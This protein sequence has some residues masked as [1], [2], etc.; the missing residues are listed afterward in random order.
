MNAKQNL[1]NALLVP[2]LKLI[3][4]QFAKSEAM[5]V[6]FFAK[7]Y[8]AS[9]YKAEIS[10]QTDKQMLEALVQAW[11]FVQDRKSSAPK[12]QFS[13]ITA[14]LEGAKP[15]GGRIY[16]LVNDM[17][18]LVDSIRQAVNRGGVSIRSV[19]NAVLQ[20][21]RETKSNGSAGRLKF[22][23]TDNT[24]SQ[25]G[26]AICCINCGVI[27]VSQMALLERELK[28]TLKHVSVAVRDYLPICQ[29][30][31]N[32][33]SAL[34][35]NTDTVPVSEKELNESVKFIGWL[36]SNHFSF[37]GYEQYKIKYLKSG[38]MVELQTDSTLGISKFKSGLKERVELSSL[39]KGT[40]EH[41]LKKQICSFA[42][43]SNR[44]KV[45]RSVHLDYVL[46]KE[47][48]SK[49]RVVT[50]HRFVG[51][52]TSSV[53]YQTALEIPLIRDKVNQVLDESGF[54]PNGHSIKDLLQVINV[55]PRDELFQISK[56][57][58]YSTALEITQIQETRISKLFVR[59]DSYGKFFSCLVYMPRDIYNTKVRQQVQN[60]LKNELQ[61]AEVEFS[62]YLSE[63]ML[64]RIHFI[65]RTPEIQ[66]VKYNRVKLE[67]QMVRLVKPWDDYFLE[68][69]QE[70]YPDAEAENLFSV[71]SSCYS[72]SYKETYSAG[73][74]VIDI[75]RLARVVESK[76]LALDLE[77]CDP[78]SFAELSFKIFSFK[79]Q[80]ILSDV[81]PVLENFGLS[82]IGE[83]AFKLQP[84]CEEV[85]WMHD[86][87]LSRKNVSAKLP[88]DLEEKFEDAFA[89]VW[90]KKTEDDSF[91]QLVIA[92][93][94]HWR[95][96]ALLRAY[97]AYLKQIQFGYSAQYIADTLAQ[98]KDI[99]NQLVGYFYAQFDP[100]IKSSKRPAA[101]KLRKKIL[102]AIDKVSNLAEDS[103]LRSILELVD[104]TLRTNYF[105]VDQEG[106]NKDYFS[107]KFESAS[108]KNMPLPKPM[109]EIFVFS[110]NVEGVH[111]RGGKVARGGLRWSDRCEDYRTEVLGLVKAQQV[112]NSIIVPVGAKG[113]FVVKQSSTPGDR[114]ELMR[115]GISCYR[116]FIRG[117]LDITDN[118]VADKVKPPVQVVRKDK[119]DPYLVVAADKGTA[120]FSDIANG[121]AEDYKF[122]LGDG[123]ASGGSN[124]YDHKQMGITAKGAWVSVQRHFREQGVNIQKQDFSVVGIGDMSG[125]VFGN[126][127]LLSKHICL[128]AAFNHLHIFIDP[129]PD[130]LVSFKE[131]QRLFKL[132]RSGWGD[133]DEKLISKGG[134][135]FQRSAKS[136]VISSE[137][138]EKFGI[139]QTSATPNELISMLLK[140]PVD[141]LWNGGI[142]TYA[143]A[144]SESH[145]E[146][147]D[148][149]NDGLRVDANELRCK[150]IGEGGNLGFTQ[151]SRIEFGLNGGISLTD[152]IDNS[153]GVDCSDH[154]VNIKILLNKQMA[155]KNLNLLE[156]NK[157]LK[158]MTAQVSSLVLD[159][160]YSQVQAIGVAQAQM[161]ARGKEHI[162]LISWLEKHADL[163]RKLEYLPT[164]DELEE[165]IV[166]NKFLTRPE[167]SIVTSYMK[168]F[169]KKELV[170]VGYIDND[171]L[172]PYLYSAFPEK[173]RE[174]HQ[175]AIEAH[176][177]RREIISTQLANSIVNL[178]GPSFVYRLVDATGTLPCE[179]VKAAVIVLHIYKID[180]TW[181]EIEALDYKVDASVQGD[182]MFQLIRLARRATR[183]LIRN[184]RNNLDFAEC[185]ELYAKKILTAREMV[186]AKLPQASQA[187]FERKQQILLDSKVPESLA[188]QIASCQFLVP[189]TSLIEISAST[190]HDLSSIFDVYYLMG[191][192]LQLNWLGEMINQLE[193]S[194]Y[195]QALAQESFL[196][197]ISW[198]Q[199][200]LTL[201]ALAFGTKKVSAVSLVSLWAKDNSEAL[202]RVK[203]MLAK[204]KSEARPD[205]SMFSVALRELLNL[206][207]T[208]GKN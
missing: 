56:E 183:W 110:R 107:F 205:Y 84:D 199:R 161:V 158:S 207:Q 19:N 144:S 198:Q 141:L 47:F 146:V 37:L 142:G 61:A 197:D 95:D 180:E 6:K 150:V 29:Q 75:T 156:R 49:G 46:L 122:W 121:I 83:K 143:K 102:S 100:A 115:V 87:S 66:N 163:N 82:I 176:Q 21:E 124:G 132:P 164:D 203:M 76:E 72:T 155:D 159:N 20:V 63:S 123:F 81:V 202:T 134:G 4:K 133:Y 99:A 41:I 17:P 131:R 52:Y 53:Y 153:A 18:F 88:A 89:A 60:L 59:R 54:S 192:E 173:L 32:V 139:E 111:L 188:T 2:V 127:M 182:M 50:E 36:L 12:I 71:Y 24:P 73:E 108:I 16:V 117:L 91:N 157:L 147:G 138:Q 9:T 148:K 77:V 114:D 206:A 149:A 13:E 43:S 166:K 58:L 112:K 10:N 5:R 195:W 194:N 204:L 101:I 28:D 165:R 25:N 162:G 70:N 208:T 90:K 190:G 137:M 98:Y 104:A 22:I 186:P 154:E 48:D 179:V 200:A 15:T 191:E 145:G 201:N 172:L 68:S 55:F 136:I 193:V 125:D 120:T 187:V 140:A 11:D 97:A 78:G 168:M 178:F 23:S 118:I 152:F 181:T 79:Q 130:S 34:L 26:E 113:G 30:A 177:L 94:I 69:L 119:D 175:E 8:F 67:T 40:V 174:S 85:I 27:S 74:G 96:A 92:A 80:L 7:R 42:K 51:L 151:R 86:F 35:K 1:D 39:S 3:D 135:V 189:A 128:Q 196:D 64:V 103:V 33:K 65:L 167:V 184:N 109:F 129:S 45:H 185:Y 126:G 171:Y 105:Q 170:S 57:Q 169:L 44:S 106:E 38:A 31:E 93:Q 160:N 14:E 62:T 116:T